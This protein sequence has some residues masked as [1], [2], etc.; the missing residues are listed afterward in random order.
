MTKKK[1]TAAEYDAYAAEFHRRLSVAREKGEELRKA[2]EPKLIEAGF[3]GRHA[4]VDVHTGRYV[5]GDDYEDAARKAKQ[6]LGPERLCWGFD[7][8]VA[9][10]IH[11]STL[12]VSHVQR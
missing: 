2:L 11:V 10:L 6:E 7:I 5:I 9:P 8:G 12:D 1:V 3:E 4:Y